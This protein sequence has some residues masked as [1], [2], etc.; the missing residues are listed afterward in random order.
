MKK[1][2]KAQALLLGL[3]IAL[4]TTPT[5]SPLLTIPNTIES[6]KLMATNQAKADDV[7]HAVYKLAQSVKKLNILIKDKLS[8][9]NQDERASLLA[10]NQTLDFGISLLKKGYEDAIYNT[11]T[12][13]FRALVSAKSTLELYLRQI[14]E[15]LDGIEIVSIQDLA[16]TTD[17]VKQMMSARG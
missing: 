16:V 15:R 9:I 17:D 12:A 7:F 5:T 2:N 3:G 8:H 11:F 6:I 4:N 10:I 14:Q 1:A 13:E